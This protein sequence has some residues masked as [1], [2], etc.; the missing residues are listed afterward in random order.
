MDSENVSEILWKRSQGF[1]HTSAEKDVSNEKLSSRPVV[2]PRDIWTNSAKIPDQAPTFI[3]E[4]D[5]LFKIVGIHKDGTA[6]KMVVDSYTKGQKTWV[7]VKTWGQPVT[8]ANRLMNWIMPSFGPSYGVRVW[9]GT[10]L[11][12]IRLSKDELGF[13]WDFD[14]QAGILHFLNNVPATVIANGVYIEGFTYIGLLG[15]GSRSNSG[16]T[17][18]VD[19]SK[20]STVYTI[21]TVPVSPG[22]TY[23]FDVA[24]GSPFLLLNSSVSIPATLECHTTSERMDSNPYRFVGIASHLVDDGSFVV[25]GSRYYGPRFISLYN[26]EDPDGGMTYWRIRNDSDTAQSIIVTIEAYNQ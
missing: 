26:L 8:D 5:P 3:D 19:T 14:Y 6:I 16:S 21:T 1:A 15:D 4:T 9:A 20:K 17:S 12:G 10:P 24:T 18:D 11:T 22:T 25:Y 23:D 13:E 2:Q 7:A